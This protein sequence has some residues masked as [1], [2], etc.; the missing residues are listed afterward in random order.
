MHDSIGSGLTEISILS[1]V[2]AYKASQGVSE[3][4]KS[5]FELISDRSRTL[6]DNMSDIVWLINPTRDSFQ[7]LVLRLRDSFEEKLEAQ[8]I[9]LT[10][11]YQPGLERIR[12]PMEYRQNLFALSKE[13]LSFYVIEHKPR[14]VR[15]EAGISGRDIILNL[16]FLFHEELG[17]VIN[18]SAEEIVETLRIKAGKLGGT[19]VFELASAS[20]LHF[21]YQGPIA[22]SKLV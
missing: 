15:F 6:V 2:A 22:N 17:S 12:L 1:D 19:V 4:E 16:Q 20:E 21:R 7:D 8:K 10:T 3:K 5:Q 11:S 13:A 18:A 9:V 14:E